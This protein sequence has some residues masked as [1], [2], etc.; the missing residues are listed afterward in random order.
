MPWI[1]LPICMTEA[2]IGTLTSKGQVTVPKEIREA[3]GASE[4]DRIVFETEGDR[5]LLRKAPRESLAA[6]FRRQKPWS[7]PAVKFQ[8]RLRDEWTDRRR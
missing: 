1:S 7:V 4:G 6:L 5:I 2:G 8:R 3:L